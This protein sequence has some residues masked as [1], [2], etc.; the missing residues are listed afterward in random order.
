MTHLRAVRPPRLRGLCAAAAVLLL[1]LAADA[2]SPW[3][4]RLDADDPVLR[5]EAV[6]AI[7]TQGGRASAE[8]LAARLEVEISPDLRRA[9]QDALGR[10]TIEEAELEAML[11]DSPTAAARAYAA[12]SL[13]HI[14]APGAA[15]A[16]LAAVRDPAPSVRRE[17]YE[18][19]ASSGDRSVIQE[20]IKAAV[21]EESPP[22][23]EVAE[24][25]ART[26]AE[27]SS[28]PDGFTA[29]MSMIEGGSPEDMR[30]AIQALGESGDWRALQVLLD[31]ALRGDPGLRPEAVKA[32]GVLGD[33]RAVPAL[34]DLLGASTG[35]LRHHAIGALAL[36]ADEASLE[37]LAALVQDPDP[38]TRVLAIRALSRQP[39][40]AA[41][42]CL[43]PALRDGEE[44]VRAEAIHALGAVG[45][46]TARGGLVQAMSDPSPF[47]RA[48]AARLLGESKAPDAV[49][50]LLRALE[51]D[52]PL[53]RL[54]AADGLANL[55][56]TEA[57]PAIER[58]AREARGDDLREAYQDILE[59][60]SAPVEP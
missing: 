16:L 24:G 33:H 31:S 19:L 42:T 49:V 36:L 47:L 55:G 29:A 60:L 59:R 54:T 57:V 14:H 44:P 25:A 30:W 56:A 41:A 7:A 40:G 38:G 23:R 35:R 28:R 13:G 20:L 15:P 5:L 6:H 48:E 37:P 18:A 1:G 27:V 17:V 51:D 21:R 10:V 12:H 32:L 26:L 34:L 52:D 46:L 53:V 58:L 45:G 22:L 11:A 2:A 43:L 8:T 39:T 50:P 9:I 3:P 4:E